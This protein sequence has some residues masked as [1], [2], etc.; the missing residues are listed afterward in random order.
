MDR[1]NRTMRAA[2]A[3]LL[4]T[5]GSALGANADTTGAD[6]IDD[7]KSR[8][9]AARAALEAAQRDYDAAVAER[10]RAQP[11]VDAPADAGET[12][13]PVST[14][15]WSGWEGS[16]ELGVTGSDGNSE[17]FNLRTSIDGER[18]TEHMETRIGLSYRY[19]TQ[20]GTENTN[21]FEAYGRNDWLFPGSRWRAFAQA[22]YEY[23]EFQAWDSRI[24]GYGGVGYELIR[25]ED[26]KADMSLLA[27]AGIGGSQTIGGPNEEFRPEALLGLD[28]NWQIK[29][30]QKFF[31]VSEF[32]PSLDDAGDFRWTTN[33][34]YEIV[35][36]EE[37]NLYLTLGLENRYDSMPG[38]GAK[39]NDIDYYVTLGWKF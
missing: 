17:A 19:G 20:N 6:R 13:E 23:D 3:T 36:D 28:Y 29:D 37:S 34:G 25:P 10:E 7:A 15:F 1:T 2:I 26:Q 9:E 39:R 22:K 5:C 24:S 32:Y 35:L 30:G 14:S 16:V 33:A 31:V 4:M 21:R 27:R 38:A 12:P 11:E 18:L 8:L